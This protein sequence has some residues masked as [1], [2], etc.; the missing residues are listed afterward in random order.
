NSTEQMKL[1]EE[2]MNSFKDLL[3]SSIAIISMFFAFL[4]Q[5]LSYKIMNRIENKK[6]AFSPFKNLNFPIAIIW[7]YLFAMII[8]LVDLDTSSGLYLVVVN[9]LALTTVFITIQGYSFIF[10]YADHKKIHKAVPITIMI[11]SLI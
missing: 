10:F 11:I 9:V 3:P 6:L 4:S 5:W 2:Q 8:A 1:F 7:F